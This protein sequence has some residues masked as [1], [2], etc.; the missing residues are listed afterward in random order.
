MDK[1]RQQ[2]KRYPRCQKINEHLERQMLS[3]WHRSRQISQVLKPRPGRLGKLL[4]VG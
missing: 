2:T 4:L 1:F 3:P